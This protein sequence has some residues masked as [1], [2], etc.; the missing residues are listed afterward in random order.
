MRRRRPVSTAGAL[1]RGSVA[2]RLAR[3]ERV[4]SPATDGDPLVIVFEGAAGSRET[5]GTLGAESHVIL[6]AER[7]DGPA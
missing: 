1:S 2:V 4:G 7:P 6:F 5:G 3:L